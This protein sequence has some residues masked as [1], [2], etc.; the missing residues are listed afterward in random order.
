MQNQNNRN[1]I[2]KQNNQRT[3]NSS[4]SS[5]QSNNQ[6]QWSNNSRTSPHSMGGNSRVPLSTMTGNAPAAEDSGESNAVVCNCGN[7]AVQLT[8]RKEGPN[9]GWLSYSF[10]VCFLLTKQSLRN[11]SCLSN[12]QLI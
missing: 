4:F 1:Y 6:N 3:P 10:R 9:T 12:I 2:S 5:N 8:V 7:D 11:C